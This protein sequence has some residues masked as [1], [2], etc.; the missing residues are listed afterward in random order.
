MKRLPIGYQ[1]YS[2]REEARRDF[3]GT[4][5]RIAMMGY[6]GVELAGLHGLSASRARGALDECALTAISSHVPLDAIRADPNQ[7]IKDHLTL[8]CQYIAVPFLD[9][10]G[11]PGMP[12]FARTLRQ[13]IEFGSMCQDAG[14]QLLYHNHDF[15]FVR[16]SGQYGLDFMYDCMPDRLL[17]AEL[18]TCWIK[19]AG[20]DPA[21]YVTKYAGRCPVVHLKDYVGTNTGG[22]AP[23][24]LISA[25][26]GATGG[27]ASEFEFRP[28]GHGCQ[29]IPSIVDASINAGA[30]WFVVEQ[31][32]S[33]GRTPLAAA[34]LSIEYLKHIGQ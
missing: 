21:D 4:L 31:D 18:D 11:R 26:G 25:D 22:P 13:M 5:S 6:D 27:D 15:E 33:V 9:E 24:A 32:L 29:D 17:M 8:G 14:I 16:V 1:L 3:P 19:Y 30:H 34:K 10:P 7:V 2:V 28:V 23:Y 20:E 12:G